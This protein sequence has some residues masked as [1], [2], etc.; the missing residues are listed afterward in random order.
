MKETHYVRSLL[1]REIG[2]PHAANAP[3]L[4]TVQVVFSK[5]RTLAQ[6]LMLTDA[7]SR[8]E[9]DGLTSIKMVRYQYV[10]ATAVCY[11]APTTIQLRHGIN[12]VDSRPQ[13]DIRPPVF[14]NP[15]LDC[16][17]SHHAQS[18]WPTP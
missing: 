2:L 3:N 1:R 16:S 15:S 18:V 10:A 4:R 12:N 7:Y 14:P 13:K 9:L 11:Y 8:P 6:T 17:I 5:E